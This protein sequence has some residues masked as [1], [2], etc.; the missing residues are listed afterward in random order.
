MYTHTHTNTYT[1]THTH[2]HTQTPDTLDFRLVF[3]GLLRLLDGV[4]RVASSRE[5]LEKKS[6]KLAP[7]IIELLDQGAFRR[8]RRSH[9]EAGVVV[10][11]DEVDVMLALQ[12]HVVQQFVARLVPRASWSPDGIWQ[13]GRLRTPYELHEILIEN[14]HSQR[15]SMCAK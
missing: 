6:L 14:P 8:R 4:A 15:P 2:T 3:L 7:G 10:S 9:T 12:A 11:E 1:H 5:P 13:R